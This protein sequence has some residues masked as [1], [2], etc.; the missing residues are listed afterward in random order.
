MTLLNRL[1]LHTPFTFR[2][3]A[4]IPATGTDS[5]TLV[6]SDVKTKDTKLLDKLLEDIYNEN[7]SYWPNGLTKERFYGDDD[8][9]YLIN[10]QDKVPVGFAAR[11]VRGKPNRVSYYSVGILPEYRHKGLAKKALKMLLSEPT[12]TK[13]HKYSVDKDNKGSLALYKA[14]VKLHPELQLNVM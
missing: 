13:E 11:Q 14:L 2:K 1:L 10:N 8:L 12:I 3:S 5:F 9:L 4:S 7:T 6:K